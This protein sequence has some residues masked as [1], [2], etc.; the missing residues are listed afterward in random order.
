MN[1]FIL[2]F[3]TRYLLPLLLLFSIYTL[4]R[5]HNDP[6][7]GF[8][9]G[10]IAAASFSLYVIAF[11]ARRTRQ[12]LAVDPRT[13]I[14]TGLVV[15]LASGLFPLIF[16][17]PFLTAVWYKVSLPGFNPFELGTPFFFDLGVFMVVA[18]VTLSFVLI[19]EEEI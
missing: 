9:A 18:G 12:I 16:G 14:G 6:G 17:K 11:S 15:A 10:L 19:F 2:R 13:L 1:S 7:G 5:G 4:Q 3:T 8:A